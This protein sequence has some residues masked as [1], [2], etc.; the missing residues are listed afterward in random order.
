MYFLSGIFLPYN[1]TRSVPLYA[2]EEGGVVQV[3]TEPGTLH[4]QIDGVYYLL[5]SRGANQILVI[6]PH[7]Q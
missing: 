4:E 2:A 7:L 1:V 3:V 6:S 5:V